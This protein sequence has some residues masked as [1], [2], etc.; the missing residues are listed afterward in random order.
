MAK[1]WATY[2]D[3]INPDSAST[4]EFDMNKPEESFF[5]AWV[6]S[7]EGQE[8]AKNGDGAAMAEALAKAEEQG[9]LIRD[10]INLAV[11]FDPEDYTSLDKIPAG[12]D[13]NIKA[14][15]LLLTDLTQLL[16]S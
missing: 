14:T 2:N 16:I 7:P 1:Q 3:I 6:T 11:G 12:R 8:A 4:V 15:Q 9:K 13:K 5:N 10:S